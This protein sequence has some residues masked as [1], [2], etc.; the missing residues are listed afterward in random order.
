[1]KLTRF[2]CPLYAREWTLFEDKFDV[3]HGLKSPL[4]MLVLV[5]KPLFIISS[6]LPEWIKGGNAPSLQSWSIKLFCNQQRL[7]LQSC[8]SLRCINLSTRDA[9]ACCLLLRCIHLALQCNAYKCITSPTSLLMSVY[10]ILHQHHVVPC[11]LGCCIPIWVLCKMAAPFY[12]ISHACHAFIHRAH[13]H[14]VP[15]THVIWDTFQTSMHFCQITSHLTFTN[16]MKIVLWRTV[17][18]T[19]HWDLMCLWV[20]KS[21]SSPHH[22]QP[23]LPSDNV[24]PIHE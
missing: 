10:Y 2:P 1:M 17:H 3:K 23:T 21:C 20:Q 13:Y 12:I 8:I 22:L 7:P 6:I 15:S 11:L 19:N 4:L 5:S 14:T 16:C 18:C 9:V 24:T